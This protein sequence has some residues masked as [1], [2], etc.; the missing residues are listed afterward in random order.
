MSYERLFMERVLRSLEKTVIE[1]E[2]LSS[3]AKLPEYKTSEA[4]GADIS[5]I[6]TYSINP[7]QCV[8]IK[9]GLKLNIPK[10]YEVQIRLRSGIAA[11]TGLILANGVGT[12]DSDYLGE[13]GVIVRNVGNTSELIKKGDRIAQMVLKPAPQADIK[14]VDSINK[15]TDRGTGGYGSTGV[16]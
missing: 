6:D 2:L 3:E 14:L 11:K 15:V 8:I 9:T 10:G 16:K 1:V 4:A 12:I 5:S 7:G 13:V